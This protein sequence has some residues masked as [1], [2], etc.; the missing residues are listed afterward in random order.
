MEIWFQQSIQSDV[1][2]V[3]TRQFVD[4]HWGTKNA[5]TINDDRFGMIA[6]RSF[7]TFA[8]RVDDGGKFIKEI[9]GT[10]GEFTI[11]EINGQLR[12]LIVNKF[13]NVIGSG[14]I[15]IDKVAASVEELSSL[16]Q[17]RLNQDFD[18][19]GLKITKFLIS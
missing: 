10:S 17:E 4:Q 6:L 12:S 5:I 15:S 11:E 9:D 19:N 8:F 1:F 14:N 16:C 7:G 18:A 3:S 2:F 13:T